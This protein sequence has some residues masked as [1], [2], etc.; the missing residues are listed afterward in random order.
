M[1]A[2]W[3][4]HPDLSGTYPSCEATGERIYSILVKGEAILGPL[5]CNYCQG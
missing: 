5:K 3:A 2:K 4:V 1:G